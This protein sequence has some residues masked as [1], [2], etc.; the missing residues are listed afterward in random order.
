MNNKYIVQDINIEEYYFYLILSV[1]T[2][3]NM[4][5]V[6][7]TSAAGG[8]FLLVLAGIGAAIY[9][10]ARKRRLEGGRNKMNPFDSLL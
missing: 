2:S 4:V 7:A 8:V 3:V 1:E 10:N 5:V 6:A 9:I